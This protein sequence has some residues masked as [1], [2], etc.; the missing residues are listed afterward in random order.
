[1]RLTRGQKTLRN[2]LLC[3]LLAALVYAMLGFPPYTVRGMLDRVERRYLLSDLEP[4]L[5]EK[6]SMRYSN[7]FLAHHVTYLIARTGDTYISTDFTRHG[8]EVWPEYRRSLNMSRGALC[9]GLNG[10]LYVAGE[11]ADAASASAEVTAQRTTRMYDPDTEEYELIIGERKTF[12]YQG[13]KASDALFAFRLREGTGWDSGGLEEVSREWY[14]A[15][16]IG[17]TSGAKGILHRDLPVRVTLY[18]E[19]GGIL[20]TLELAIDNYELHR[21]W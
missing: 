6:S 2:A 17:D 5:V 8:L 7:R 16:V 9:M 13:G 14:S 3:I 4:V 19:A 11:F 10:T 15:R 12:T 1:M 21:S 20:D 18:D